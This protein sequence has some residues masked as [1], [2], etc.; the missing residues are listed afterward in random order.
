M[1]IEPEQFVERFPQLWH[2]AEA[3]SWDSI[4][5]HGLLST[6]ALLDLYEV[7]G[8]EREIIETERRADSV[9]IH[10]PE[11]GIA[12]IRDQKPL[13]LTVLE[14]TIEGATVAEFCRIL[15]SRVF[16]WVNKA[17]LEKLRNAPPYKNRPHLMLTLDTAQVVDAHTDD[18]RLSHLNSGAVY[19]AA[20]YPRGPATFQPFATYPWDERRRKN[21]REPVVEMAVMYSV[22]DAANMVTHRETR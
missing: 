12:V 19:P 2:M 8:P 5:K 7:H 18:I 17:R 16:F 9:T 21:S 15:N 13:N 20:N 6:T 14:R 3:G 1:G 10:H 11:H 4:V 22:P